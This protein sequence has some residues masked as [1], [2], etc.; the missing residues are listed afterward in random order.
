MVDRESSRT[1]EVEHVAGGVRDTW[2]SGSI[3]RSGVSSPLS[4]RFE[5]RAFSVNFL[6]SLVQYTFDYRGVMEGVDADAPSPMAPL[7]KWGMTF[8]RCSSTT[9]T[10][11]RPILSEAVTVGA[12][13]MVDVVGEATTV[14]VV[15]ATT[16][17]SPNSSDANRLRFCSSINKDGY[18]TDY[19]R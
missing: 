13:K 11:P 8:R 15:A 4:L 1:G 17:S 18:R 9:L 7:A 5:G 3:C 12:A 19:S 6:G 2:N 16:T 10:D 14:E